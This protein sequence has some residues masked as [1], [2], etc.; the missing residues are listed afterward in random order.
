MSI[1]MSFSMSIVLTLINLGFVSGFWEKWLRAFA[2]GFIVSFPTSVL[3]IPIVRRI[4]NKLT[5]S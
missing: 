4:V 3:I 2:I 1:G 5:M